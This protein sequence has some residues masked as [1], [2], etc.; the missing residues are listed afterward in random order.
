HSSESDA[1]AR[2]ERFTALTRLLVEIKGRL[3]IGGSNRS[4]IG[5]TSEVR[6]DACG[7]CCFFRNGSRSAHKDAIAARRRADASNFVWAFDQRRA[8][9]RHSAHHVNF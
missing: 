2:I 9:F 3:N 4:P 6:E 1:D 8:N 5:A 7:A